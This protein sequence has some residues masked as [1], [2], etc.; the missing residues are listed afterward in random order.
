MKKKENQI[1][2]YEF[3]AVKLF[4]SSDSAI[5]STVSAKHQGYPFGSFVTYISGDCRTA[6][7]Y[8]S[9]IAQHTKNLLNNS[10][11]CLTIINIDKDKQ[12]S[13]RLTL[14]GDLKQ[15]SK[16]KIEEC[17][18][19]YYEFF[20][21]SR[22]YA[23]MHG[24]NFYQFEISSCRWIGG[25][26]KIAWLKDENWNQLEPEWKKNQ[27]SI[28]NHMNEDHSNSICSSLNS[29]Y[30][31]KDKNA[32]MVFLTVDGY[33]VSSNEKLYF[34]QFRRTAFSSKEYKENL[35]ALAHQNRKFEL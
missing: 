33:Y 19:K 32:K 26:G 3:N 15:L 22:E 18:N 30:N 17:S 10:K 6:Y 16:D 8:L 13:E 5:L 4:R 7:L 14:L 20:P 29:Q 2:S 24:F 34:I 1:L 11:S 12:N 27:E 9:D 23:K 28:I 31:I 35:V 25:F 21:K